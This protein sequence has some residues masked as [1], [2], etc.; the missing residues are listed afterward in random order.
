MLELIKTIFKLSI[1]RNDSSSL[2]HV[3]AMHQNSI[4]LNVY[5]P[6]WNSFILTEVCIDTV[7][8]IPQ[9]YCGFVSRPLQQSEYC[10]KASHVNFFSVSQCI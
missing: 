2:V 8:G 5:L 1:L 4:R 9:G 3:R 7:T 10:N 6:V